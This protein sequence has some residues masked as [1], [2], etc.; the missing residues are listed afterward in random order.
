MKEAL[1]SSETSVLTR[2]TRRNIPEDT[3]LQGN[4]CF[5]LCVKH[6]VVIPFYLQSVPVHSANGVNMYTVACRRGLSSAPLWLVGTQP[7]VAFVW[8]EHNKVVLSASGWHMHECIYS[9]HVN[10]WS[11]SSNYICEYWVGDFHDCDYE[12]SYPLRWQAACWRTF[13]KVVAAWI[14]PQLVAIILL[15]VW[16]TYTSIL[17]FEI[18]SAVF[19]ESWIHGVTC[20]KGVTLKPNMYFQFCHV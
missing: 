20:G 10:K 7:V 15:I 8:S 5:C 4:M 13:R 3:I 17:K 12:Q 18:F 2:A 6:F 19:L 1:G 9:H 11:L 14:R 16:L